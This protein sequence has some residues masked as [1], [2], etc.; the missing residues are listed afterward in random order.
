MRFLFKHKKSKVHKNKRAHGLPLHP[1]FVL[2]ND[3]EKNSLVR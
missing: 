1:Y 2:L 3:N